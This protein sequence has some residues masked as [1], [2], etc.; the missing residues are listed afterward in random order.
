[1]FTGVKKRRG[2][3]KGRNKGNF[4]NEKVREI[5][6][7]GAIAKITDWNSGGLEDLIF[8]RTFKSIMFL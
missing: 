1:M 2:E 8:T 7:M 3:K 6:I 5:P 4:L